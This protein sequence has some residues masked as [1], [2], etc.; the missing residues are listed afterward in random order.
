LAGFW[1][2]FTLF[3]SAIGVV[4]KGKAGEAFTH[5][6]LWFLGLAIVGRVE[7]GHRGG[8]LSADRLGQYFRPSE[9]RLPAEGGRGAAFAMMVCAALVGW[10]ACA[11]SM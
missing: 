10:S 6:Q 1:G 8:I 4:L 11:W 5:E 9:T 7:C 2:K 3:S